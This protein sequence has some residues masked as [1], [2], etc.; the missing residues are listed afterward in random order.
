[1][2]AAEVVNGY[3]AGQFCRQLTGES[4]KYRRAIVVKK[5]WG[6]VY[7]CVCCAATLTKI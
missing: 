3:F 4:V 7:F 2:L 6:V 1:M 5:D